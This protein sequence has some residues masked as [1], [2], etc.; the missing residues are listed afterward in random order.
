MKFDVYLDNQRLK[1]EI[2]QHLKTAKYRLTKHAAEKQKKGNLDLIDTLHVLRTGVHEKDKTRFEDSVWRY[3]IR[4]KT[5]E[6]QEVRIV[7]AFVDEMI[8]ITIIDL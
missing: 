6:Y 3:A 8:I 4:G 5:E 2:L 1:A 7:I